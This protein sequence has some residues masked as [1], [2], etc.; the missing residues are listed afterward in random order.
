MFQSAFFFHVDLSGNDKHA[1]F[2]AH[3]ISDLHQNIERLKANY[4]LI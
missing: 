2:V 1:E 4:T 3:E